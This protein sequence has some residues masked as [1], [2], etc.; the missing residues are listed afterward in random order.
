MEFFVI[1]EVDNI[2]EIGLNSMLK[3]IFKKMPKEGVQKLFFSATL[4]SKIRKLSGDLMKDF[5]KVEVESENIDLK[6]VEQRVMYTIKE[7]KI[8]TLFSILKEKEIRRAIIFTNTKTSVDTIVRKLGEENISCWGLHSGKSNVHR[9][10]AVLDFR[11][12]K[13]KFLVATDLAAR[14]LDFEDVSCVINFEIAHEPELYIHRI[15][16]SWKSKKT[17]YLYYIV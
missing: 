3:D 7:H 15:G 8:K 17:R 2:L 5:E 9:E 14:G 10:K 1:D 11:L 12:R 16:E 13:V 6:L 4:N